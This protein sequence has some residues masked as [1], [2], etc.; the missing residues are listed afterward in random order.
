MNTGRILGK[1]ALITAAANGIGRETALTFAREGA[2]VIA[3]DISEAGL[4]AL[5]AENP[6]ITTELLDVTSSQAVT[7]MFKRHNF[8]VVFNCAGFVHQGTIEQC[9][10]SA[11][12][13]SF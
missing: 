11:W 8:N 3:T 2:S 10:E 1:R 12:S 5:A 13:N 6:A 9:D 7:D 4:S